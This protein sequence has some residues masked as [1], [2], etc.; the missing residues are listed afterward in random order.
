MSVSWRLLRMDMVVVCVCS[1]RASG[2]GG[3]ERDV[4]T[5]CDYRKTGGRLL[6]R[7]KIQGMCIVQMGGCCIRSAV[8]RDGCEAAVRTGPNDELQ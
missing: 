3:G 8:A 4:G 1:Q 6:L 7:L 2:D 5:L